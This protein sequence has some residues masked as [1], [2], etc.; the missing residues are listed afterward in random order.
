M[1]L[2]SCSRKESY[3]LDYCYE[4]NEDTEKIFAREVKSLIPGVFDG[5]NATVIAYGA[6]GSAKT[7]MIQVHL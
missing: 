4:Q 6:R 1:I 2:L 3:E 7:S 5:H